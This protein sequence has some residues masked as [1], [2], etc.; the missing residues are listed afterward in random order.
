M[1]LGTVIVPNG[2]D[3]PGTGCKRTFGKDGITL[4]TDAYNC[5]FRCP[6]VKVI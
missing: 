2:R 5:Y 4:P 1:F 6:A 3:E